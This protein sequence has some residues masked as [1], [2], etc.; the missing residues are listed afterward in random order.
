MSTSFKFQV[1]FRGE[2]NAYRINAG[3]RIIIGRSNE[4]GQLPIEHP[5]LSRKHLAV[6]A[7]ENGVLV[8]DLGST[9]GTWMNGS[10]LVVG[11]SY[12][13][14][15]K[16]VL[17]LTPDGSVSISF[18]DQA[19]RSGSDQKS[20]AKGNSLDIRA[21]LSKKQEV[22]IGRNPNCDLVLE[23]TM[24]SRN[25]ARL[26]QKDGKVWIE[27]L[28]SSNGVF[29]N[30]R[31]ISGKVQLTERDKLLIGLYSFTLSGTVVDLKREYAI[32]AD[33][34]SKVFSNGYTGLQNTSLKFP[35]REFIALMGPSGCGKSTLLKALNGDSPP[36][37]GSVKVF[38]LDMNEH[39]EMIKHIIGYVPQENIVHEEL[40]VN[41][42]LYYSAKIR[43]PEDITEEEIQLRISE[44]LKSL[45]IDTPIIRETKISK[46]SGGQKKRVSIAVELLN[47][48]KIL[49]L[50]E[51]TS[52]LDPETIEEFLTCIKQLCKEGTTVIM[53]THKPEDLNF[54][55]RVVFMGVNGY[56][57]YD[58]T[59]DGLLS[60]YGKENLINLYALLSAKEESRAWHDRWFKDKVDKGTSFKKEEI[61]KEKVNLLHQT[62]WLT[63]R[64]F[65]IKTGNVKNLLIM[66][67][68]PIFIALLIVLSFDEL[69]TENALLFNEP[70]LGVMFLM[71]IAAIW[72]GVSNSA[73]EIV[74]EKDIAKR[75]FMLNV[76]L[77]PYLF[78]KQL[79]LFFLS[80]IQTL[81]FLIILKLVYSDLN[82]FLLLYCIL[83]LISICSIQFGLM[84]SSF[85]KTSEEVMSLLP[86][87]LMPQII[88]SGIL[89]PINSSLTMLLSYFTIGRW[90]TELLVRIH[91]LEQ[92]DQLFLDTL[93][94]FLYP[95][96]ISI[97]NSDS[98][99]ANL[100]VLA[101]LFIGMFV[102]VIMIIQSRNN[103]RLGN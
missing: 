70:Q 90:G 76:K 78:S 49:F 22:L 98:L 92:E 89:Q 13:F 11:R 69:V 55:D 83:L 12:S 57:S 14:T 44:V 20:V 34:I 52:P 97:I 100:T 85:T 61:K 30:G 51:P 60:H 10:K 81:I 40:T 67:I 6:T 91:D 94:G 1:T 32:S 5:S 71:A 17:V 58:G 47:K 65:Q 16:D 75:E 95:E 88:L 73:K 79:V 9:N 46:L 18:G 93:R 28:N 39:F 8:E 25:H 86:I 41:Q 38:D 2:I 68:Q 80:A 45:K 21:V 33:N 84:L 50:D 7:S 103:S 26:F 48:P 29:V 42:S 43:L 99:Q 36:T 37:K 62:Y 101:V 15:E 53:V 54:V 19:I 77:G 87:A 63:L 102:T 56:L 23:D 35:Y 31:K 64:Y 27:D 96:N 74:G 82:N 4:D 72:F 66:L 24:V 3:N 59:K